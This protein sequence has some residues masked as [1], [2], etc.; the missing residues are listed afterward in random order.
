MS[1]KDPIDFTNVDLNDLCVQEKSWRV[2]PKF[3]NSRLRN[4]NKTLASWSV[5]EQFVVK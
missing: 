3:F 2:L 4:Q 1:D 5:F